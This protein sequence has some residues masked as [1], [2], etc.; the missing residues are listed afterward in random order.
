MTRRRTIDRRDR[1]STLWPCRQRRRAG[2]SGPHHRIDRAL[3]AGLL[4]RHPGPGPGGQ[5]GG[6]ARPALRRP[7][8]ARRQRHP[9][10]RRGGAR[11]ARRLH[12]DA[13]RG[14]LDHRAA[15]DRAADRLYRRNRSMPICQTFK[16]DQVIVARPGTYK[17]AGRHHG[18]EQGEARR[19][20]LRQSG[21]RHD[22][23]SVDGR[24]VADQ[25]GASST[26]CRSRGRPSRSR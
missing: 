10:H 13:W 23:A 25:Q 15:A 11:Q 7:Q 6:A 3:D 26:T 17:N 20:E 22:P 19:P 24:A 8:Q 21:P 16:N 1:G 2:L 5:H 12:A 4:G 9:R 18:R 14:V